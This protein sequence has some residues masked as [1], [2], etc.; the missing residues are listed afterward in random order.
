[1]G[2]IL[3]KRDDLFEVAGV[4]GGKVRSCWH[5]AQGA[6]GL[7]TAGS[8]ASPQVNIV[9]HIAKALGVP[10]RV[11]VPQ[12]ALAPEVIAARDVGAQ[13]V[14]HRAGY[15]NVI[16][17]RA[18]ADAQAT[19]WRE[20][21]FGME[22]R[23]AVTA[24]ASQVAGLPWGEFDRIVVPVG[25]G[26]SLAGVLHGLVARGDKPPPVLGVVVGAD[27]VKRLDKYAPLGWRDLVRLVPAGLDYHK[28]APRTMLGAIR[29]DPIYEAKCLPFLQ[30]RD[31]L[32]IV[33]IRQT[34]A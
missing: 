16:I 28:E 34:A 19:G 17:A 13:I 33:G 10:C 25:S 29:L 3:L 9:A 24:T 2:D 14:Q 11:H 26:M 1:V 22:C 31:L 4:R 21:P 32:W 7:I 30:P 12:G 15:N 27:P 5:L 18:R 20:I 8:R 23:E 6:P